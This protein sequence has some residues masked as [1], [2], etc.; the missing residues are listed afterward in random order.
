MLPLGLF[1]FLASGRRAGSEPFQ[2]PNPNEPLCDDMEA[3][4]AEAKAFWESTARARLGHLDS[5]DVS[6][7]KFGNRHRHADEAFSTVDIEIN[8]AL[9]AIQ[10]MRTRRNALAPVAVLPPEVLSHI[11]S[12]LAISEPPSWRPNNGPYLGWIVMTTHVCR[13]WRQI[14]LDTASLWG[15]I[16]LSI[17]RQWRDMM[18]VRSKNATIEVDA[19]FESRASVENLVAPSN[20]RRTRQLTLDSHSLRA[21]AAILPMLSEY[22]PILEQLTLRLHGM[23]EHEAPCVPP[24]AIDAESKPCLRRLF[25]HDSIVTWSIVPSG[26]LTHLEITTTDPVT[27]YPAYITQHPD[28][29]LQYTHFMDFLRRTPTLQSLRIVNCLPSKPADLERS[30]N[31]IAILSDLENVEVE[32]PIEDI[33]AFFGNVNLS[34]DTVMRFKSI[35]TETTT[36]ADCRALLPLLKYHFANPNH[37][38]NPILTLALVD[39]TEFWHF[40]EFILGIKVAAYTSRV[41]AETV[42][43]MIGSD[44]EGSELFIE[45]NWLYDEQDASS[46]FSVMCRDICGALPPLQQVTVLF[47][48]KFSDYR[49]WHR[50]RS[51]FK[52]FINVETLWIAD[53]EWDGVKNLLEVIAPDVFKRDRA[54]SST[55]KSSTKQRKVLFPGLRSLEL[56]RIDLNETEDKY[57]TNASDDLEDPVPLCNILLETLAVRKAHAMGL[58]E[59]HIS[60]CIVSKQ[61]IKKL[62]K[63]VP[64]VE[65]DEDEGGTTEDRNSVSSG[66]EGFEG[67]EG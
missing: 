63:L 64:S 61:W 53:M 55:G 65:W 5:V 30:A 32:G 44:Y 66:F 33:V 18:L 41:P 11:F 52:I 22:A 34:D 46:N 16:S 14:A 24:G 13:H 48:E 31:P 56:R 51:L 28:P 36:A 6:L 12:L 58:A 8:A 25:I 20:L 26:L 19:T 2:N 49:M 37:N 42:Q 29:H 59:V 10:A 50:W 40:E 27:T 60:E 38:P 1:R 3:Q 54:S 47:V 9:K 7:R 43:K 15:T 45:L 67:F 23:G 4:H 35:P 21:M 39:V 62:E 57:L 17:G